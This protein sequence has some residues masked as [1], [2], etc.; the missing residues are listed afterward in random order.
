MS[1]REGHWE[2]ELEASSE[3]S[4]Q[5]DLFQACAGGHFEIVKRL[6]EQSR[7]LLVAQDKVGQM[8]IHHACKGGHLERVKWLAEQEGV[9]LI[10][11]ETE[12]GATPIHFACMRGHLELV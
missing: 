4:D 6:V 7:V 8:P 12:K 9:S 11:A 2:A 10:A 1:D 5:T 3:V